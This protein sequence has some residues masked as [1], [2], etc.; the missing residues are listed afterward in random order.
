MVLIGLIIA[1]FAML[2]TWPHSSQWGY[3]PAALAAML[4]M[5]AAVLVEIGGV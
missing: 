2:P 5:M 1:L 3:A 4:L